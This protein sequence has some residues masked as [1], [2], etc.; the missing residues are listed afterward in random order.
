MNLTEAVSHFFNSFT[1][2]NP[3]L[4]L[5][6]VSDNKVG[7]LTI[8]NNKIIHI[9]LWVNKKE[10]ESK[11]IATLEISSSTKQSVV[12]ILESPHTDEYKSGTLPPSPALGKTGDNI[13]S[14]F[15][16]KLQA[17]SINLAD[18]AY[19]IILCNAIQYQT[20]LG[21]KTTIFRDRIWIYLW[22]NGERDE[23]VRRLKH[24]NPSMIINSC[25]KGS[26]TEDFLFD[27]SNNP[28]KADKENIREN[29]IA[30][31]LSGSSSINNKNLYYG[32]DKIYRSS[33]IEDNRNYT[34][35]GFVFSAIYDSG[36]TQ[37]IYSSPHPSSAHYKNN[38]KFTKNENF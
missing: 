33:Y 37:N 8:K 20:S 2:S 22:A 6:T 19:D 24:Y 34:L 38:S 17:T 15:K 30:H 26:H 9:D 28:Q 13:Q 36:I 12:L 3:N 29:F 31:V 7:I 32:I 5:Q 14:F 18:G 1:T 27:S 16:Q 25:T 21:C 10:R 23:F 4:K 35:R 11:G